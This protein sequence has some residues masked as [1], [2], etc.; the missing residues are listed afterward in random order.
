MNKQEQ[1]KDLQYI[2]KWT[3]IDAITIII[4]F[5]FLAIS[6]VIWQGCED[7][8]SYCYRNDRGYLV[9]A[10]IKWSVGILLIVVMAI[11]TFLYYRHKM[12]RSKYTK[13]DRCRNCQYPLAGLTTPRC[14]ECG[15]PFN[16]YLAPKEPPNE[17]IK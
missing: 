17:L 15:T 2:W 5:L 9:D 8:S 16:P 12:R 3:I 14:P 11:T 4:S 6:G 10:C 7:Y 1:Q 13:Y